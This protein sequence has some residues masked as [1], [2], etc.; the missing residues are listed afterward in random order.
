MT[1]SIKQR[2]RGRL[3]D[4]VGLEIKPPSWGSKML[5]DIANA[6]GGPEP[7]R[8]RWQWQELLSWDEEPENLEQIREIVRKVW[9]REE[10]G[11]DVVALRLGLDHE[12]GDRSFG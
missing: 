10:S 7:V 9:R 12:A 1:S 8:R 6:D 3:V 11:A 5:L 4:R 2:P